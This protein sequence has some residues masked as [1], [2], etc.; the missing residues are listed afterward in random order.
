MSTLSSGEAQTAWVG[1]DA[2]DGGIL[3]AH[4][5]LAAAQNF[6]LDRFA[7]KAIRIYEAG[8]GSISY[9]PPSLV[10]R[11]DIT[12]VD[13]DDTQLQGNSYAK[14][15]ISSDIQVYE[16]PP[17]SF[18]LVVC[19]NVIEHIERPD[20]ALV[21]FFHALT[22]AGLVFIAAPNPASFSGAITK[23][24]PHW[25]HVWFYRAVLGH[26]IA[27]Q[28]GKVPFRTVYHPLV[29]PRR[30][31]AFCRRF[32]Y[33]VVYFRAFES[34][35]LGNLQRRYP[36]LGKILNTFLRTLETISGSA[37]RCGDYHIIL[38][39]PARGGSQSTPRSVIES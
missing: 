22:P 8:G 38:E 3:T 1:N 2:P 7:G 29:S 19:Y 34:I 24:T 12:V 10:E 33:E 16:F 32:G 13:I 31:I 18:D 39:K 30:L 4:L 11:A 25:L 14:C 36:T 35:Q 37:L 20:K 23:Y 5:A 27:G 17:E 15:K 21:N 6:L 9:L 26:K 28:P